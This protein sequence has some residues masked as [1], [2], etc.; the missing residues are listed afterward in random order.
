M[1]RKLQKLAEE[2]A[3]KIADLGLRSGLAAGREVPD[4]DG[5]QRGN[6]HGGYLRRHAGLLRR[7]VDE[8]RRA[9]RL[10]DLLRIRRL[11]LALCPGIDMLSHAVLAQRIEKAADAARVLLQRLNDAA[12]DLRI[13]GCALTGR[14]AGQI[15]NLV[16]KAHR[17]SPE[18]APGVPLR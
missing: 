13:S 10:L 18:D 1:R 5:Q 7:T 17:F 15:S 14:R 11:L 3:R 4:D 12:G 6:R 16:Q 9:Q 2:P 8:S